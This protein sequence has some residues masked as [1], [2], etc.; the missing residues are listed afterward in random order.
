MYQHAD[1]AQPAHD[2][3]GVGSY[4]TGACTHPRLQVLCI[5]FQ[6]ATAQ[7]MRL[8]SAHSHTHTSSVPNNNDNDNNN[9]W[10]QQHATSCPQ[11]RTGVV[12]CLPMRAQ[13]SSAPVAEL[14]GSSACWAFWVLLGILCRCAFRWA[15]PLSGGRWGHNLRGLLGVHWVLRQ[16]AW[17]IR[18]CSAYC[19]GA[20]LYMLP[21]VRSPSLHGYCAYMVC[22][23]NGALQKNCRQH[24]CE[25]SF[26]LFVFFCFVG[27][28]WKG[29]GVRFSRIC[30]YVALGNQGPGRNVLLLRYLMWEAGLHMGIWHWRPRWTFLQ[31][32]R[33]A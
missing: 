1:G 29:S 23:T 32:L 15:R 13:G 2:R 12:C 22:W 27:T 3:V 14:V 28:R 8:W 7:C 18:D 4:P 17:R 11:E 33:I 5:I 10:I 24:L 25:T 26:S 30:G 20:M 9:R 31:L 21:S 6:L 16:C 19:N